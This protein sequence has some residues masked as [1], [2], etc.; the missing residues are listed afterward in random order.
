MRESVGVSCLLSMTTEDCCERELPADRE[1]EW[2]PVT[3]L[4]NV[5]PEKSGGDFDISQIF[6][7]TENGE[8]IR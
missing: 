2:T 3:K 7:H 8:R 6:A 4:R 5:G 1:L